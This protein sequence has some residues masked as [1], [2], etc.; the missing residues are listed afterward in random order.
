MGQGFGLM[1]KICSRRAA[2]L[3]DSPEPLGFSGNLYQTNRSASKLERLTTGAKMRSQKA[4]GRPN[5]RPECSKSPARFASWFSRRN[6][7]NFL[8]GHLCGLL[9]ALL[10]LCGLGRACRFNSS[11]QPPPTLEDIKPRGIGEDRARRMAR[12][13][14]LCVPDNGAAVIRRVVLSLTALPP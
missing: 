14:R 13:S 7:L 4:C 2:P 9:T 11:R 5:R 8:G 1:R 3:R 12:R 10:V 6:R